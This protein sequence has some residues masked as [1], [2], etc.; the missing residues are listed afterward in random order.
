SALGL[1]QDITENKRAESVLSLEHDVA[2]QLAEANSAAEGIQAVMRRVCESERWE[3]GRYW[4]VDPAAGVLRFADA[5]SVAGADSGGVTEGSREVVFAPGAGLAGKVWQS[6]EP[7]W[8]PDVGEDPR[9]VR[10]DLVRA[11]RMR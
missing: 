8:V 6:G 4:R 7:L 1:I 11:A 5:W 3:F 9:V 10:K 2:R